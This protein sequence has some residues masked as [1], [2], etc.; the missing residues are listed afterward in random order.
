MSSFHNV[1]T[2]TDTDTVCVYIVQYHFY[3][4]YNGQITHIVTL[5]RHVQ[6]NICK[7]AAR[8]RTKYII[9]LVSCGIRCGKYFLAGLAF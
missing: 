7:Y 6:A 2:Y 3:A 9:L 8:I 5:N 4:E 1:R